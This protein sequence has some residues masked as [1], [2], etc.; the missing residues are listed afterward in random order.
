MKKLVCVKTILRSYCGWTCVR[1]VGDTNLLNGSIT[2]R[3]LHVSLK[4]LT[5]VCINKW[6]FMATSLESV[7]G[8]KTTFPTLA[9]LLVRW[10]T[11]RLNVGYTNYLSGKSDMNVSLRLYYMS[12]L[13]K[14]NNKKV[15]VEPANLRLSVMQGKRSDHADIVKHFTSID[16][17]IIN[18]VKE[19]RA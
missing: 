11:K 12:T 6:H 7:S 13:F 17:L 1:N 3:L 14:K 15:R 8:T 4:G 19:M 16:Y 9:L 18:N 10:F 2:E 5:F